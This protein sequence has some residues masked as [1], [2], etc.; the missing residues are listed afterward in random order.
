MTQLP[1][2]VRPHPISPDP[3]HASTAAQRL[4]DGVGSVVRGRQPIL[5]LI[6]CALLS[7]GHVLLQDVPGSGKTTIGRAFAHSADVT[8]G[9]VQ[10]T[11]DMLP[12][13]ITGSS[14]WRP[15]D[16]TFHFVPGPIFAHVVLVDELNRAS[17]RTQ[18]AFME[19]LEEHA[20]T[21]DGVRHPLPDPFFVIATQN[22]VEQYG[23][24]PLPEGQ[25]DR[26]TMCLRLGPMDP[27]DELQV[28]REQVHRSTVEDLRPV[29]DA[30]TLRWL[31]AQSRSVH[32]GEPVGRYVLDLVAASR[33]HPEIVLG[34]STRAAIV[35]TRAAQARALLRGRDF[36]TPDD[37]K[38]LAIP[39]L[40]HRLV[41]SY[42]C[43]L[44]HAEKVVAHLVAG[45]QVPL[46]G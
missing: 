5:E 3:D 7:G 22:P 17:S 44:P 11:S 29:V 21:V 20:V 34:A 37:V 45:V 9:R 30:D 14:V 31:R 18:S 15:G 36:V 23:T 13:D 28:L 38:A 46:T 16:G 25:L 19:A 41:F 1:E 12:A 4:L 6:C 33:Q 43:D 26:F 8:F 32:V 2:Q 10:A 40:A 39:V 27:A 42:D 35:L 24:F